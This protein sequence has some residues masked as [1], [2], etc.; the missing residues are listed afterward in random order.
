MHLDTIHIAPV[1]S[2][3]CEL[4]IFQNGTELISIRVALWRANVLFANQW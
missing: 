2:V 4:V 1:L 3:K